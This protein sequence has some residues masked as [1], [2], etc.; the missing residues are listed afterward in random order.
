MVVKQRTSTLHS[1]VASMIDWQTWCTMQGKDQGS[2]SMICRPRWAAFR[3][4]TFGW[5]R[6]ELPQISLYF[7]KFLKHTFRCICSAR[8]MSLDWNGCKMLQR[9][10]NG[11]RYLSKTKSNDDTLW[12]FFCKRRNLL[13]VVVC[14]LQWIHFF[15]WNTTFLDW[16]LFIQTAW[17]NDWP[18]CLKMHSQCIY[19][20]WNLYFSVRV[21]SHAVIQEQRRLVQIFLCRFSHEKSSFFNTNSRN[22]FKLFLIPFFILFATWQI[23]SPWRR[24]SRHG[25]N[26]KERVSDKCETWPGGCSRSSTDPAG[27]WCRRWPPKQSAGDWEQSCSTRMDWNQLRFFGGHDGNSLWAFRLP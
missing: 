21:F 4:N 20:D 27:N 16:R 6:T 5:A 8:L 3:G 1:R 23:V 13:H 2:I 18:K 22:L 10:S 17:S 11:W 19:T 7:R 9:Y 26:W 25:L 12:C 15:Y 14:F 24:Q